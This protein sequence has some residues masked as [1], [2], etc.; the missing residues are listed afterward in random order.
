M[1]EVKNVAVLGAGAM[2][3]QIAALAAEAGYNVKVR[4]IEEKFLERGRQTINEMYEKRISR[5]R[6]A[7]QAR[8]EIMGRIKFLV[9]LK[10]S[11]AGRRYRHRGRARDHG[12][13]KVRPQRGHGALP[14]RTA[15]SP[16]T[17]LP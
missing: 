6:M 4:D 10:E 14:G 13:E 1:K 9:D 16:P 7:S 15:S 5:G 8:D 11:R 17:P 2:G 12:P 3:A